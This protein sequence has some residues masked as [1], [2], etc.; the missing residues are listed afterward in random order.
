M[1]VF[2]H[3]SGSYTRP[4]PLLIQLAGLVDLIIIINP[5]NKIRTASFLFPPPLH[6]FI[7]LMASDRPNITAYQTNHRIRGLSSGGH[8]YG[9]KDKDFH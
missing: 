4:V 3:F 6:S 2:G 9:G 1:E 8:H 7:L 5:V